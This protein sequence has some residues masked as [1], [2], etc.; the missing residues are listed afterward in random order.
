MPSAPPRPLCFDASS[1]HPACTLYPVPSSSHPA[2][3]AAWRPLRELLQRLLLSIFRKWDVDDEARLPAGLTREAREAAGRLLTW[4]A[5]PAGGVV[6]ACP[7]WKLDDDVDLC[8]GEG[9]AEAFHL[10]NRRHHC[11]A[12]GGI[13]CGKCSATF[14]P[15]P[16]YGYAL[17][18]RCCNACADRE[19]APVDA[20]FAPVD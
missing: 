8:E 9:C 7:V 18:Q 2:A 10:L 17:P 15:L 4:T 13:F 12:C 11:R 20:C 14:M 19:V 1:S 6:T 16:Q 3:L 5:D